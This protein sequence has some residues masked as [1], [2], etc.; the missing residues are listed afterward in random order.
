M[1]NTLFGP[2]CQCSFEHRLVLAR[3]IPLPLGVLMSR[4]LIATLAL[5]GAFLA[6]AS[7]AMAAKGGG[8][9][10]GKPSGGSSSLSVV[11]VSDANADGL[12][13]YGDTITFSVSTKAT[14]Q[15]YVQL[16]C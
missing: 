13:N 12:P 10:G 1:T 5:T 14:S 16:D 4:R 8:G 3:T 7:P 9:G 6:V 2:L 11:M 15:P